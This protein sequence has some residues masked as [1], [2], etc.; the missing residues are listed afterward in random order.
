MLVEG[1]ASI[2]LVS[3]I[4][5]N[6]RPAIKLFASIVKESLVNAA[7]QKNSQYALKR[8]QV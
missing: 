2:F 6:R 3:A 8:P 5:T 7:A 1:H 4:N